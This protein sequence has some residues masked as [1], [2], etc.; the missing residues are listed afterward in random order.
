MSATPVSFEKYLTDRRVSPETYD[1]MPAADQRIWRTDYDAYIALM[2]SG[3]L[4]SISIFIQV[5]R[6]YLVKITPL[7][8]LYNFFS[9]RLNSSDRLS[10]R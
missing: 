10:T 1:A 6:E 5:Y 8:P 7:F 4:Y 2:S 3:K 9:D